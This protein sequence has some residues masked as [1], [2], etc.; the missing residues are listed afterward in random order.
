[1]ILGLLIEIGGSLITA[2]AVSIAY[3]YVLARQGTRHRDLVAA[4]T[5]PGSES[6][7]FVICM[8][9]LACCCFFGGLV[10]QRLTRAPHF[11]HTA[12]MALVCVGAGLA[13]TA[14]VY[15]WGLR[16]IMAAVMVSSLF[17]GAKVAGRRG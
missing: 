16:L 8:S 11:K 6:A 9:V 3:M 12:F 15:S 14:P 2:G 13:L 5:N 7:F 10:C 1:L 4:F 17:I